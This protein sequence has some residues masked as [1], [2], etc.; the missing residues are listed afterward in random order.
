MK[1]IL[2]YGNCQIGAISDVF[3]LDP[4]LKQ[5]F[6]VINAREYDL[7]HQSYHSVANFL[8]DNENHKPE[9]LAR[10]LNDAD[11]IIFQALSPA[12][13]RPEH[14]LTDNV[15]PNFQGES[16]CIPSSW[17]AGYMGFPYGFPMLDIFVWLAE[18]KYTNEQALNHLQH[19]MIPNIH[20]IH[21]YYHEE[22]LTGLRQR[23]SND[24]SKYN[25]IDMEHWL[26]NNYNTKLITYN[27]SHPTQYFF[28]FITNQIINKLNVDTPPVNTFQLPA[29]VAG[30]N[31]HFLPTCFKFFD[32]L[33]PEMQSQPQ[34]IV[35]RY[36]EWSAYK[37]Y[38]PELFVG[39]GMHHGRLNESKITIQ[40]KAPEVARLL[41]Y[42]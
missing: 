10:I 18:Q 28:N 31:G 32:S 27:H 11:I 41:D 14:V 26:L 6:E 24:R 21:N 1:K 36:N 4:G 38:Q 29:L 39:Q 13:N 23:A 17:Y 5:H 15:I 22:S 16:I 7:P 25:Y 33:F 8:L 40:T 2:F 35:D 9:D 12:P 3:R 37:S 42:M 34:P 30:P 19:E 20:H